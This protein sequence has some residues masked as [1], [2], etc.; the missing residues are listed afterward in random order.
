MKDAKVSPVFLLIAMLALAPAGRAADIIGTITLKG[1]PPP[2]VAHH[3]AHGQSGLRGDV[4]D[5]AHDAFLCR[6]AEG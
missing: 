2:E 4:Q 6:R 1:T 3:T 5:R